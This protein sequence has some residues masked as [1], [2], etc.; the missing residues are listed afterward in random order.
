MKKAELIKK[1]AEDAGINQ[2]QA[3]AA[4]ESLVKSVVDSVNAGEKISL[5]GFGTF[6]AKARAART[7]L[8]PKTGEKIAVAA[9]KIPSFKA[10]S[11]FKDLLNK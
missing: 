7:C 3:A 11:A 2:K 1:I 5:P 10:A 8:N 9:S 6:E 4:L